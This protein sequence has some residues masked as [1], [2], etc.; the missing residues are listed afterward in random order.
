[1]IL[2]YDHPYTEFFTIWL[3]GEEFTHYFQY[4]TTRKVAALG[5]EETAKLFAWDLSRSYKAGITIGGSYEIKADHFVRDVEADFQLRF[6]NKCPSG[7]RDD[8]LK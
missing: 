6:S 4:D 3:D 7:V 1:M 5:K 8:L 2:N